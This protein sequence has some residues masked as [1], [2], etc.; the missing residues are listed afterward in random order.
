MEAFT[1]PTGPPKP[2]SFGPAQFDPSSPPRVRSD[3]Q[4]TS[5]K[6]HL[7]S[8]HHHPR[9]HHHH[10]SRHTKSTVQSAVQSHAPTS[11][12]DLL[13]QASRSTH[14]SPSHSRRES[15]A[16]TT[17]P[18][19]SSEVHN[20]A[21][22]RKTVRPDDVL[23]ERARVKVREDD[24]RTALNNLAEQSLKTSRRLDDTYYAILEKVSS[25]RQTIGNLQ[26]LSG[27][28]KEL[29]DTFQSDTRELTED[30]Q[31]Q[32]EGFNNFETQQDQV[33][34]LEDRIRAGKEKADALTARLAEARRKVEARA[35]L[36]ADWEAKTSRRLRILWGIL[37]SIAG[38]I[39][40]AILFQQ[41]K[42][43]HLASPKN[44]L[45][46]GSRAGVLNAPIPDAVKEALIK[47]STTTRNSRKDTPVS[48]SLTSTEE[49]HRLRVFDEL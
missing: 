5:K 24:L 38:L 32:F 25:L 18:E 39:I 16:I 17:I 40:I 31:S 12:G 42:P 20:T 30:A 46:F 41:L 34:V 14:N 49:D 45:D 26:E 27:L 13:K 7:P 1:S 19:H 9:R 15:V 47:S 10:H 22:A 29:H 43:M 23:R 35:K 11:F 6:S 8:L 44:T 3:P 2:Q 36:E 21:P 4:S 33:L 28:T 37:G 48:K